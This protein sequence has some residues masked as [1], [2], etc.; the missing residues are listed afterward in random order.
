MSDH[1]IDQFETLSYGPFA[2]GQIEELAVG[3][4]K[5]FD[6]V[7]KYLADQITDKTKMMHA[8]LDKAGGVEKV[9]YQDAKGSP[10]PAA[11]DVLKRAIA[12]AGSHKGG[13][14]IVG[15]ILGHLTR[16]AVG[17]IRPIKLA[18]MLESA[19]KA[20]TSHASSLG[21]E[22][23]TWIKELGEAHATLTALNHD[24]KTA[25]ETR[26]AI[27]PEV[28]AARAAWL[29]TYGAAKLACEAALRLHGKTH[30]MASIFDDLAE[31]HHAKGV[32]DD[33]AQPA[34]PAGAAQT[35]APAAGGSAGS[36]QS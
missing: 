23:K 28:E 15:Q 34:S 9:T 21:S 11:R 2:V 17:R 27:T 20:F 8:A 10:V 19:S 32:H 5:H 18:G 7:L 35:G 36:A 25:R 29:V 6:T 22:G 16:S 26:K 12:Y 33:P 14:A 24:V 13:D 31:A 30:L 4:D 3:V 1:Y